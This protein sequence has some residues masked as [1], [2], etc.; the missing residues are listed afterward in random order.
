MQKAAV[1]VPHF[2]W[3]REWY[4]PFQVFRHRLVAAL[5]TVLDTAEASP[6]FRFTVDGQLAAVEDY[7]E[8]FPDILRSLTR[9]QVITTTR[10]WLKPDSMVI[11]I[12]GPVQV[13]T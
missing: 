12:A 8:R 9:E 5:D 4:E 2:H 10:R 7:L 1:F 13:S 11:G 3:D 6:D